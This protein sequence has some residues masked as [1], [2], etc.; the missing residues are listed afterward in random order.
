V[1]RIERSSMRMKTGA[2][3][4]PRSPPS[5]LSAVLPS[6]ALLMARLRQ[7]PA[8][9]SGFGSCRSRPATSMNSLWS[10]WLA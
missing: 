4:H 10:E 6:S 1:I 5:R 3:V 8:R 9:A 7:L 2:P